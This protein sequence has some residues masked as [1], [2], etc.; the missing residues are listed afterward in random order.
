MATC[1]LAFSYNR[2]VFALPGRIDD[3][4]SQ[5]CNRLIREKIAEP[6]TSEEALMESLGMKL[7]SRQRNASFRERLA[8]TFRDTLPAEDLER[9]H[10]I[11]AIISKERGI[12]V[13][14]ICTRAGLSYSQ[15]SE[16]ACLLE[17]EGFISI[18]LLQRCSINYKNA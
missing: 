12:T 2:D 15:T 17:I 1:R 9:L 6:I 7:S 3:L 11:L 5:G 16:A 4:R 14:D 8:D 10:R 13:E 18:D